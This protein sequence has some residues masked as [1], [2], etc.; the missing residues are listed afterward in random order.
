[1]AQVHERRVRR[2]RL[3]LWGGVG[4]GVVGAL[5]VAGIVA[6]RGAGAGG[7][8]AAAT[9]PSAGGADLLL[10]ASAQVGA[11][12]GRGGPAL[13]LHGHSD[14]YAEA[15]AGSI[16][17]SASFTVSAEVR[18]DALSAPKAA[19]S[20]GGDGFFSLYLGREDSSSA[21]RNRWVFKVQTAA[22]AGKS[23]MALSNGQATEGRWTALTGVY[24]AA[25]G[26]VSL[27]VDGAPAQS[28]PVPGILASSGPVEIG[29]ARYKSHWVDFW[30]GAIADVQV[31]DRPLSADQVAQLAGSGSVDVPARA[32]WLRP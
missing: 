3:L 21:T 18:N 28:L 9:A 6:V 1:M 7:A 22:E 29:R 25:A 17:T 13:T 24:D 23:I 14:G 10:G 27:Y 19:V 11:I 32:S 31:W 20:Q 30:D 16:D 5:A 8:K 2:R 26:T 15:K 12:D 4:V